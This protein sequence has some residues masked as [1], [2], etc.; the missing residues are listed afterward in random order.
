MG[1][2]KR[3]AEGKSLPGTPQGEAAAALRDRGGAAAA[4]SPL[5]S[6]AL[7]GPLKGPAPGK[8][9]R[10]SSLPASLGVLGAGEKRAAC[11]GDPALGRAPVGAQGCWRPPGSSF[12][13][14]AGGRNPHSPATPALSSL[15]PAAPMALSKALRLLWKQEPG[16]SALLEA[17]TRQDCLLLEAGTVAAL[18]KCPG[19]GRAGRLPA[20][21]VWG[22]GASAGARRVPLWCL[23][24]SCGAGGGVP[25]CGGSGW[26][27][28]GLGH[29]PLRQGEGKGKS[30]TWA[31][32][33]TDHRERAYL[34]S[35][36]GLQRGPAGLPTC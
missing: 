1:R 29:F 21:C 22:G 8:G 34:I 33:G 10:P 19:P 35:N 30:Q 20:R 17:R 6:P 25:G 7:A 24:D 18:S 28:G 26:C 16:P 2:E 15:R 32:W 12:A 9:T 14:R 11:S 3:G 31:Q 36:L 4:D 5:P 23:R 13:T 27:P